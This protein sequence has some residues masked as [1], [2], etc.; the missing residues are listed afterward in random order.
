MIFPATG[1]SFSQCGQL[2]K[3]PLFPHAHHT[4]GMNRAREGRYA[5]EI[6]LGITVATYADGLPTVREQLPV[7]TL[8]HPKA[9]VPP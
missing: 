5:L 8:H 6:H 7:K 2:R 9:N 1:F 3:P 4:Y